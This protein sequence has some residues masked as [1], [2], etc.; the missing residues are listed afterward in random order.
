[1]EENKDIMPAP[2][3]NGE[4]EDDRPPVDPH[5]KLYTVLSLLIFAVLYV[6]VQFFKQNF[7]LAYALY[8]DA[9]TPENQTVIL[10]EIGMDTLPEGFELQYARLH[11][12]FDGNTLYIA[13]SLPEELSD[14]EGFAEKYIPY[15]YG[16]VVTDERFTIYPDPD[17]TADYVYGDSYVCVDNPMKSCLIYE[18]GSGYTAVF[19]TDEYDPRVRAVLKDGVKISVN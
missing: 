19:R 11:R 15:E 13:V 17:M 2:E 14:T 10:R 6:G 5:N 18:D 1:M 7:T 3:N 4:Q 8:D 16:D 9:P 12:N